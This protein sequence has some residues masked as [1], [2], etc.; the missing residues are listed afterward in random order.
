MCLG[1]GSHW[2]FGAG[3]LEGSAQTISR[4]LSVAVSSDRRGGRLD[5][6]GELPPYVKNGSNNR[7]VCVSSGSLA[8]ANVFV[9]S[10]RCGL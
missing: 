4:A 9:E 3:L 6:G 5:S 7:S 2:S 1:F 8:S 10:G